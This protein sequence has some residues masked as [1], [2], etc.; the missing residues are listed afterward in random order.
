MC[1][2]FIQMNIR[3]AERVWQ[4][5][6]EE[7]VVRRLQPNLIRHMLTR[8]NPCNDNPWVMDNNSIKYQSN[9]S[10]SWKKMAWTN[11]TSLGHRQELC[12]ILS[13]SNMA[14]SSY[15]LDTDL[16]YVWPW[17]WR[18]DSE[19]TSW[20]TLGSWAAVVWNIQIQHGSKEVLLEHG[21]FVCI[22]CDLNLWNT[23]LVLCQDTLLGHRQLLCII[24]FR[25]NMAARDYGPDKDFGYVCTWTVEIWPWTKFM[26]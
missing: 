14:V 16:G 18:H 2:S 11:D 7:N 13:I 1:P 23:T 6:S 20:H 15:G 25:S 24:L 12:E 4:E 5:L 17:P 8:Q 21:F 26:T 19:S 3:S 22:H 10:Y 9:P